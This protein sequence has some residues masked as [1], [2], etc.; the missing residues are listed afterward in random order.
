MELAKLV[1][2]A[3]IGAVFGSSNQLNSSDIQLAI[4]SN[5]NMESITA[6]GKA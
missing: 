1:I 4:T 2:A 5:G 3:C 6:A